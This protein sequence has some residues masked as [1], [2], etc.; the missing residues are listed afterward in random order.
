MRTTTYGEARS[1]LVRKAAQT[2]HLSEQR[3]RIP[4]N[5]FS[6]PPKL[7]SLLL[8]PTVALSAAIFLAAC[9]GS[10]DEDCSDA[11]RLSLTLSWT[12]N[13]VVT[14]GAALGKVGQPLVAVPVIGGVPPACQDR[15]AYG[16]VADVLPPGLS[17]DAGTGRISG[18]ATQAYVATRLDGFEVRVP[19]YEALAFNFNIDVEP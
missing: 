5:Y 12:S 4:M 16:L 14:R 8:Q 13:G 10:D 7:R 3:N 9:G 17:F 15:L 18:T 19:G 2:F 11:G 1:E 6:R